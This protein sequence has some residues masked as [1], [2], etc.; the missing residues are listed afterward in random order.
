MPSVL[1]YVREGDTS[2]ALSRVFEGWTVHAADK[3]SEAER[4]TRSCNVE[5]IVMECAVSSDPASD[6]RHLTITTG[7]PVMAV[8]DRGYTTSR[9][10]VAAECLEAGAD[11]FVHW[12]MSDRELLIRTRKRL[13]LTVQI[14]GHVQFDSTR[15]SV[16]IGEVTSDLTP[17]EYELLAFLAASPHRAFS[18]AQI[19]EG[20]WR[21]TAEWQSEAT[22][23]EHIYRLR[24]KLEPDPSEPKYIVTV[25]GVGYQ[26]VADD[27][28]DLVVDLTDKVDHP[29]S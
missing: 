11:D 2:A 29:L 22:V 9:E 24:Q 3:L 6:V 10:G 1:L 13:G 8:A 18:R 7:L 4:I 25:S 12:P 16:T 14:D 15:L 28:P 23:T 20:V 19:L 26:F 27:H 17:K 21:S 5:V